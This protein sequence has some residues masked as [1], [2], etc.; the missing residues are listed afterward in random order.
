MPRIKGISLFYH[1]RDDLGPWYLGFSLASGL[2]WEQVKESI[3]FRRLE[4]SPSEEYGLTKNASD[5][6]S[7]LLSKNGSAQ[8]TEIYVRLPFQGSSD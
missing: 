5:L 8:E 1:F 4:K 7:W 2:A 3:K 6:L